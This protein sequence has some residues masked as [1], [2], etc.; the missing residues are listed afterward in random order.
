M[1]T[2][3]PTVYVSPLSYR[4][5]LRALREA[6]TTWFE[7]TFHGEFGYQIDG[8]EIYWLSQVGPTDG[9]ICADFD[10]PLSVGLRRGHNEGWILVINANV[11]DSH[12][13]GKHRAAYVPIYQAKVWT[14][15][16]GCLLGAAVMGA[17]F[18]SFQTLREG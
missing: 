11:K 6:F 15:D 9:L 4:G 3:M 18:D 8:H 1:I 17:S 16:A 13:G 12:M 5:D 14:P 10:P 2:A 7:S